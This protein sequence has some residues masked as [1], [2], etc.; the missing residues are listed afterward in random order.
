MCPMCDDGRGLD[1]CPIVLCH[2]V[3]RC[4]TLASCCLCLPKAGHGLTQI[5]PAAPLQLA[6]KGNNFLLQPR[7]SSQ[8]E[9]AAP[10]LGNMSLGNLHL[11]L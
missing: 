8:E 9:A 4:V 11:M 2:A 7:N 5:D 3:S 10:P 1:E 6:Q